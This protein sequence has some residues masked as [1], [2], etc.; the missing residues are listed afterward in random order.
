MEGIRKKKD[1]K[2]RGK[3]SAERSHMHYVSPSLSS[4]CLAGYK[5]TP[6]GESLYSP[7]KM[8]R[9]LFETLLL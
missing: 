9:W 6:W 7:T 3:G 8:C 1:L 2:D 4:A 5:I